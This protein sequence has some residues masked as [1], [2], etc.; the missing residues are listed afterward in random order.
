MRGE[1]KVAVLGTRGFPGVQGGVEKHAE[2]LYTRLA[3]LGCDI[4]VFTRHPY[5]P[6]GD[7]EFHGVKLRSLWCSRK[8]SLEAITHT[9]LGVLAARQLSPDVLHIHAVGPSLFVPLAKA[10]GIKVVMTHHGPDYERL[11]WGRLARATLK[12]G[13]WLGV[14]YA[15]EVIAVSRPIKDD[16]AFKRGRTAHFIPNGVT[17][18]SPVIADG[19]LTKWNIEKGCYALAA[20]RF[21]PEKGLHDLLEAYSM[22]NNPTFK[23]VIAGDSD[24]EGNYSRRLKERAHGIPG[25]VLTGF[26]H[27]QALTELFANAGLF[28]QPSYYEG[29]PIAVLEALSYGLPVLV[30]DIPQHRELPLD[31]RRYFRAGDKGAFAE[32]LDHAFHAGIENEEL[33]RYVTCLKQEYDWGVI[34]ENTMDVYNKVLER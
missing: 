5:C 21:V 11:K 25:V 29:L 22:L 20:C 26:V 13:E 4:T 9:F 18:P 34:A 3:S 19:Q 8:K 12:L 31:E 32:A 27:G 15:N 7:R 28:V 16:I 30:S 23:L 6:R 33:S 24:H 1:M 17:L 10:L 2:E 14:R